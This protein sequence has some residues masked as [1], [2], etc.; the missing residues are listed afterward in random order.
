MS[1]DERRWRM[2]WQSWIVLIVGSGRIWIAE[3]SGPSGVEGWRDRL[4]IG[5]R[6]LW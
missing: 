3:E 5:R 4:D 6:S 1:I 2:V